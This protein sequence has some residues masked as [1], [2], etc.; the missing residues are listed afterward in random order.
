M[1]PNREKNKGK[2]KTF[3]GISKLNEWQWPINGPFAGYIQARSLPNIGNFINYSPIQIEQS[4][5]T[6]IKKPT[7][8][9]STPSISQ[10]S[11]SVPIISSAENNP[12]RMKIGEIKELLSAKNIVFDPNSN[13][14]T[15]VPLLEEQ[16]I[17]EMATGVEMPI[18]K[19][20]ISDEDIQ[21]DAYSSACKREM[22]EIVLQREEQRH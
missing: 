18:S 9:I 6:A 4:S 5:T 14:S 11:W 21:V 13:K 1:D 12:K 10:S 3:V 15:L 17:S 19:H 2:I 20:P 16:L 7:P 22:A 8:Q